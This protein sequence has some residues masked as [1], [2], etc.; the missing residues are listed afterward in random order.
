MQA[1][2]KKLSSR[3]G[4]SLTFALL[5]FLVCAVVGS[6]V[7][8]AGTAAAGRMSQIAEM[9]QRYY[10]V[11][12]AAR[13]L[14]DLIDGDEVTIVR[15]AVTKT[16]TD[17]SKTVS[18]EYAYRL[19]DENTDNKIENLPTFPSLTTEAAYQV[20]L[21]DND[22]T[23]TMKIVPVSISLQDHA[24]TNVSGTETIA[25][26]GSLRFALTDAKD[27]S[28]R[29]E[30]A[31]NAEKRQ[32]QEKILSENKEIVTTVFKWKLSEINSIRQSAAGT[33]PAPNPG[34]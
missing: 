18:T 8:T 27:E 7:L 31:F 23:Y 33:S 15:T 16:E 2:K 25:P 32:T 24:T 26:D 14:I 19:K 9:D 22:S 12:S 21:A 10:S 4:A 1:V 5:I 30:I 28:Y 20:V 17:G 6:V 3:R 29:I 13:L 11:N 34:G